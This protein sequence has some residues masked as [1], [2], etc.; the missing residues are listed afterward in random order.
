M[1]TP[2]PQAYEGAEIFKKNKPN[3][4]VTLVILFM[5]HERQHWQILGSSPCLESGVLEQA[6]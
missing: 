4:L 3:F 6:S 1:Y 5:H 2:G